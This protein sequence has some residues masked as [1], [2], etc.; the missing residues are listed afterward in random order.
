MLILWLM[1]RFYPHPIEHLFVPFPH[2]L[3]FS[4]NH[5]FFRL[6]TANKR[7]KPCNVVSLEPQKQIAT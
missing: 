1:N 5:D 4:D 7:F 3:T 2:V 6:S